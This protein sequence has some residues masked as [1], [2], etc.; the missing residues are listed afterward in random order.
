MAVYWGIEIFNVGKKSE[1][2]TVYDDRKRPA[3]FYH[4]TDA[5]EACRMVS[6]MRIDSAFEKAEP[7]KI[8]WGL[9]GE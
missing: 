4:R 2:L 7:K 8:E 5:I 3:L 9:A 1:L 6:S